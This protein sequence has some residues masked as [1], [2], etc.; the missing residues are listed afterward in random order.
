MDP[1]ASHCSA[2]GDQRFTA[3]LASKALPAFSPTTAPRAPVERSSIGSG[4]AP[5]IDST[6]VKPPNNTPRDSRESPTGVA[7]RSTAA[8]VATV[9]LSPTLASRRST[10]RSTFGK[11]G[12]HESNNPGPGT[13]S[14]SRARSEP[15]EGRSDWVEME[16]SRLPSPRWHNRRHTHRKGG[17]EERVS[18]CL[19]GTG[20]LDKTA[21]AG[22]ARRSARDRR[23][24]QLRTGRSTGCRER[25][26]T[27][28]GPPSGTHGG[29]RRPQVQM[30]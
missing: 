14:G 18:W 11:S 25:R 15:P 13:L 21:P 30:S 7:A 29:T 2:S 23:S 17:L 19:V 28:R 22:T 5:Q 26:R 12:A 10:D 16:G 8:H 4:T 1:V 27:S 3:E 20:R 6:M 24:G 9:R